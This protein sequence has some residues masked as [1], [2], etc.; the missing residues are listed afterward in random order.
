MRFRKAIQTATNW[1]GSRNDA[2]G[3]VLL[4][5]RV[6]EPVLDPFRLCVSREN[7][8][9]HLALLA[10]TG[11]ALPLHEFME[12]K[13]KGKLERG[14]VCVT[15]D[16][17]YLDV[18]ENALPLLEK[19]R[20]PATVFITTGNL[21]SAFWWDR[22]AH[23]IYTPQRLPDSL[24]LDDAQTH[25]FPIKGKS[26]RCVYNLLYPV[27]RGATPERRESIFTA[28]TAQLDIDERTGAGTEPQRAATAEE[29]RK[30]A[31]HPLITIGAHTVTHSRLSSLDFACQLREI[32][33]SMKVL[34]ALTGKTVD[35][36]SYPFG[37]KGRDYNEVTLQA[38][39]EAGL[40]YAF[41]A[42]RNAVTHKT[43]NFQVP[44][45]W[46]HDHG[47]IAVRRS[48]QI[49]TGTSLPLPEHVSLSR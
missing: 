7:F 38:A 48:V 36:L 49:W 1:L 8:E 43:R 14:S 3:G 15:F 23:L 5:H 27:L 20:I 31:S 10:A 6:D 11:R 16:D 29:I 44:R 45:L 25:P 42:D 39:A 30:A 24:Y 2:R 35:T 46:I 21:G 37:L 12:R 34:S 9:K 33:E 13:E 22:L 32:E 18:F 47:E 28:L 40:K 41:T 19:Y 17:G 4:Y 26:D